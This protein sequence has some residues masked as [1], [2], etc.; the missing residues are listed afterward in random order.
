MSRARG[1]SAIEYAM[2]MVAVV[3]AIAFMFSY[4]RSA[5]TYR[6]KTGSDGIGHGML[7]KTF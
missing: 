5:M 1:Q 7:Y 3:T 2:L 4:V 6:F